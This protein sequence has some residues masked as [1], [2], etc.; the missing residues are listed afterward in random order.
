[1]LTKN[2]CHYHQCC[3]VLRLPSSSSSSSSS[4]LSS[5]R[6]TFIIFSPAQQRTSTYLGCVDLSCT[7]VFFQ[8]LPLP[9]FLFYRLVAA[10]YFL[11]WLIYSGFNDGGYWFIYLSNW[12]LTIVTV[13]FLLAMFITTHYCCGAGVE[14]DP[15]G[16][17]PRRFKSKTYIVGLS[18]EDEGDESKEQSYVKAKEEDDDL[19]FCNKVSWLIF[20][21]ASANSLV[22]TVAYWSAV[23]SGEEIDGLIVNQHILPAVFMLIEVTI[24][25]I[26]VRLLHFIYSH[27]FASIYVLF[28]VI[29]WVAG[30]KD[31]DGNRYIY[32]MLNY[33]KHPGTAILAVFLILII[34]QSAGHL[35]LFALFRFR[36]WLA[37][38]FH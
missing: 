35:F 6:S 30:G 11:S 13:H 24:S 7:F 19:S 17:G 22:I 37:S 16:F 10:F 28:T 14:D 8:W 36:A 33:Q 31:K 34:L 21:I 9:L 12:V 18:P 20:T 3:Q 29:Y 4:A 2:H 32:K 38:K 26:P 27:V 25:N 1:M 5:S 15:A 23:Y